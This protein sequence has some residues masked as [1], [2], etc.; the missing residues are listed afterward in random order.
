MKKGT[1]NTNGGGAKKMDAKT[2]AGIIE[3]Y[4]TAANKDA[5]LDIMPGAF[6]IPKKEILVILEEEGLLKSEDSKKKA[7]KKEGPV[8]ADEEKEK[9]IAFLQDKDRITAKELWQKALGKE[10]EP[11]LNESK[12]LYNFVIEAKGWIRKSIL[13]GGKVTSGVGMEVFDTKREEN[14]ASGEEEKMPEKKEDT[15]ENVAE[16]VI[17]AESEVTNETE[18]APKYSD[19]PPEIIEIYCSNTGA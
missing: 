4:K 19:L 18:D 6:K 3:G 11:G 10:G 12:M 7:E 14:N 1:K 9:I 17:S 13:A 15:Q 5:V 8:L 16:S 2:R